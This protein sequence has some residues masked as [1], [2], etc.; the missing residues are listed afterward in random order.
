MMMKALL[1][2]LLAQDVDLDEAPLQLLERFEK[3]I[4]EKN[5][6]QVREALILA[7]TRHR[8]RLVRSEPKSDTW[9]DVCLGLERRC[10]PLPDEFFTH[11][12]WQERSDS[13]TAF[14]K[15]E[16]EGDLDAL[17][18]VVRH[19]PFS[20]AAESALNEIGNLR[21]KRGD[22][23]LAVEAWERLLFGYP[24]GGKARIWAAAKLAK[25]ALDLR[26]PVLFN[27]IKALVESE[28]LDGA[29]E[30]DGKKTTL[31]EYLTPLKF[32]PADREVLPPEKVATTIVSAA[33]IQYEIP[34]GSFQ[35]L[36]K[37]PVFF[38]HFP[39]VGVID[40]KP[41]LVVADGD[42]VFAIDPSAEKATELWSLPENAKR[43]EASGLAIASFGAIV[44]GTLA[45]VTM[46]ADDEDAYRGSRE[47][48][49]VEALTGKVRWK[50]DVKVLKRAGLDGPWFFS[51]PPI[52]TGDGVVGGISAPPGGR[53]ESRVACF[54]KSTG[55]LRWL[56]FIVG[57]PRLEDAVGQFGGVEKVPPRLTMVTSAGDIVYVQTNVGAVG[58]LDARSGV[59]RWVTTYARG[60]ATGRAAGAPLIHGDR[61]YCLAQDLMEILVFDLET[62]ARV[63]FPA[64]PANSGQREMVWRNITQMIGFMEEWLFFAGTESYVVN[65]VDRMVEGRV[66]TVAGRA[67]SLPRA[68]ASR[69]GKGM[70][71]G[72]A[73][74]IPT[75][76]D[77]TGT[78]SVYYGLGSFK[79][80]SQTKWQVEAGYGN[81]M[82]A[83][84]RL[85][86]TT[87]EKI[88]VY[89]P[90]K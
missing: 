18:W 61:L 65:M 46:R 73:V 41:V 40:G 75:C 52:L 25:S 70:I 53:E 79:N 9:I 23:R 12:Y 38:P 80:L 24:R 29:L 47:I 16:K 30:I 89:E 19:Y 15:A 20:R 63:K 58:A 2:V 7:G 62:G 10:G 77:I 13:D 32:D 8:G 1:L 55:E 68:N 81:L 72:E 14:I 87:A 86:V 17:D 85:V 56:R 69:C 43:R 31:K 11:C 35:K 42:R 71:N 83:G 45:Y 39:G 37:G 3:G 6:A 57:A 84:G 44:D 74:Y 5:W 22:G 26:R 60:K 54:D 66:R 59:V 64:A 50:T 90:P 4:D 48:A 51:G 78:L 67:Y 76:E 82:I 88:V 34:L 49:C 27:R 21:L 33:N 28:K 36:G